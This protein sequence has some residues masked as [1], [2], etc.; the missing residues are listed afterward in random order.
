VWGDKFERTFEHGLSTAGDI[1]P[2]EAR[3][4]FQ[5]LLV[6][7]VLPAFTPEG[8]LKPGA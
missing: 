6:D 1:T 8:S 5:T 3:N 4:V 2:R 7:V